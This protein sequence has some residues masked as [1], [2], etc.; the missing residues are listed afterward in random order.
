MALVGIWTGSSGIHLKQTKKNRYE[1]MGGRILN[2]TLNRILIPIL[3]MIVCGFILGCQTVDY[4]QADYRQAQIDA[5]FG[6]AYETARFSQILNP[7]AENNL[8][9][10]MGFDGTAAENTIDKY[11][12]DFKKQ[13][14]TSKVFNINV[15]E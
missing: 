3:M 4:R 12:K 15:T 6:R 14:S 1:L 7:E 8:D 11:Q 13:D 2:R 9:P 10:V 5:N